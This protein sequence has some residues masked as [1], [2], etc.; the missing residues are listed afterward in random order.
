MTYARGGIV[1]VERTLSEIGRLVKAAGGSDMTVISSDEQ[2][3]CEFILEG[4]RIR[5]TCDLID[6]HQTMLDRLARAMSPT[7][8]GQAHQR[9]IRERWRAV[10]LVIKAKLIS[11]NLK[12]ESV[13]EAFMAQVVTADRQ[14][15]VLLPEGK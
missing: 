11:V 14:T 9:M 4:L 15:T 10:M 6:K 8:A 2:I 12:I 3:G 7:Q 13:Q 1:P 5:L